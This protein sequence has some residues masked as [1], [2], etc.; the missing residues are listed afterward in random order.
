MDFLIKG[1]EV[2]SRYEDFCL[3]GRDQE[4][5]RLNSVLMRNH[6]NS[7]I[8][9]GAGGVGCT[10]LCVGIQ[11]SKHDPNVAFDILGKRLFWLDSD[12][13]FS[14]GNVEDINHQFRRIMNRLDQIDES[15]LIVEDTRDLLE[16]CRNTG[17]MHILTALLVAMRNGRM[18]SI[19]ETKD[20]DLDSVLKVHSDMRELFT[21]LPIDE[22]VGDALL[23]IV[24]AAANKLAKHHGI[25]IAADAITTAIEFTN[26]YHTRDNGL[27]RAQPERSITLLDRALAAYRLSAHRKPPQ[28]TDD[29]W[30]ARQ[31]EMRSLNLERRDGENLVTEFEDQIDT[32][33]KREKEN[34]V[35]SETTRIRAFDGGGL[36][37]PEI[38]TLK[39]KIKIANT[40]LVRIKARLAAITTEINA[41]LSL[42]RAMVMAEFSEI[43]GIALDKLNQ[44]E[45]VKLRILV[46]SLERRI[47][48]QN[49]VVQRVADGIRVARVGRRNGDQPLPFLFMGPSGVGKTEVAKVIAEIMLDDAAAL[50]RFDMSE[51]MEKHAVAKMIGAPPGYEGFEAGGILTNLMRRSSNRVLL[52]DEIEKGH[53]DVFNV[54]L[55]ILGDG[56]LTD[57]IGRTVSFADA[58]II[59]TTNIGQPFFLDEELSDQQA[60]AAAIEDLGKNFKGEFLNRFNGRQN[61]YCFK[62]LDIASMEKIVRREIDSIDARYGEEGIQVRASDAAIHDF[63][64]DQYDPRFGARGLP[65]FIKANLEPIIVNTLLEDEDVHGTAEVNYNSDIKRFEVKIGPP[66]INAET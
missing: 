12:G 9:V 40:D 36:E 32:I 14:S 56:R 13:L 54:F 52:F 18:Q 43:S 23:A 62:K 48:G 22:P 1:T 20:E 30:A 19:F 24:T 35:T 25:A 16:A 15:V 49:E 59:F 3:V 6:A 17:T 34:V 44:N 29:E 66:E 31:K 63:C 41:G 61:I 45:R 38:T 64:V 42:T 11:A 7:V 5:K 33:L 58:I 55:Q 37:T 8:L 60:E 39:G 57:N 51:Y 21:I 28:F 53:P 26:R 50:S 2:L 47:F 46:T 10:T 65:G 4:L 27:S